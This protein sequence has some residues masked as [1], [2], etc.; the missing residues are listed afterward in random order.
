VDITLTPLLRCDVVRASGPIDSLTVKDLAKTF[1]AICDAGRF[2]IVFTMKAV[3]FLSSAGI[4]ELIE[5]Q[6]TC[7]YGNR[8]ELVLAEVPGKIKQVLDITGITPLF[9]LYD[10]ETEAVSS[11]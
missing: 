10:S 3:H 1:D 6:K 4:G 9:K 7:K 8:G 11:F 2:N 5:R